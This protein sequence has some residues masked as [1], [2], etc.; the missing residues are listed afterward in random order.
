MR[1][2]SINGDMI[3]LN[4]RLPFLQGKRDFTYHIG[5]GDIFGV[6]DVAKVVGAKFGA[7]HIGA[8]ERV[9]NVSNALMNII[10][11]L[12]RLVSVG[13]NCQWV[14]SIVFVFIALMIQSYGE[15]GF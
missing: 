6:V 9:E 4:A 11:A 1:S 5:Q 8:F 3:N 2:L 12:H 14:E 7:K 15:V 10:N 13:A